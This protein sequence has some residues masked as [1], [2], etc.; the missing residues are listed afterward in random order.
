MPLIKQATFLFLINFCYA[1]WVRSNLGKIMSPFF[2]SW[3]PHE[4][5]ML[6]RQHCKLFSKPQTS[7]QSLFLPNRIAIFFFFEETFYSEIMAGKTRK[8]VIMEAFFKWSVWTH[9]G[10]AHE[11][12]PKKDYEKEVSHMW[13][14][15]FCVVIETKCI[16]SMCMSFWVI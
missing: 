10:Q 14:F 6:K 7:S 13:Y 9:A 2:V 12:N 4:F 15:T 16:Y 11:S 5:E 3:D 1:C 8:W